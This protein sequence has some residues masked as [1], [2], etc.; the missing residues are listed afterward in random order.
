[1]TSAE[2]RCTYLSLVGD[3]GAALSGG[4]RQRLLL[5]RALYHNPRV[6]FLDE[7]TANPDLQAERQIAEVI[8]RM[9][10]TRLVVAH[11]PE[12][13]RRAD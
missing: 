9:K 2:C 8:S 6:F 13:L 5:S 11:R 1:M 12:L 10:V 4:Q 3:M 7:G